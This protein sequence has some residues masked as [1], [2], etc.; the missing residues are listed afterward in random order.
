MKKTAIDELIQE[1]E[2]I[3]ATTDNFAK[4]EGLSIAIGLCKAKLD[5]EEHQIIRAW[6]CNWLCGN[7][8][9]YYDKT[10]RPQG[11]LTIN[12]FED[13]NENT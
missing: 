4:K 13:E 3:K 8:K 11:Q 10:Y 2:N 7:G 9:E 6:A 1:L 12:E 5:V